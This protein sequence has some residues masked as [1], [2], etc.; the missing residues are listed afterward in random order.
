MSRAKILTYVQWKLP[1]YSLFCASD[2]AYSINSIYLYT[3]GFYD[4]IATITDRSETYVG[5]ITAISDSYAENL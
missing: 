5:K 2:L 1:V 4:K 3:N